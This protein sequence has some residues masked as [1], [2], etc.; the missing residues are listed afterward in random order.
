MKDK[1]TAEF[2]LGLLGGIF[3]II[4][5]IVV[6]GI[7]GIG[8][9]LELEKASAASNLGIV[10]I[11]LSILGIVGSVVVKSKAKLGGIFMVVAAVGGVISIALFYIVP[12]ILL[13]I[14]GL[15][16]IFKKNQNSIEVNS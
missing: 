13:L 2:V 1:R 8:E 5:G 3:G 7:G 4:G 11:V 14:G 12:A 9:S 15:M 10:A 16:G 6:L